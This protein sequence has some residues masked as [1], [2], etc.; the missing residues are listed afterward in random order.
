VHELHIVW[1]NII[2]GISI[3]LYLPTFTIQLYYLKSLVKVQVGHSV[4]TNVGMCND[5]WL[6]T[7]IFTYLFINYVG[8]LIP[9]HYNI[10]FE[11][12]SGGK[13][14]IHLNLRSKYFH[15]TY[16]RRFSIIR[17]IVIYYFIS[18]KYIIKFLI[19]A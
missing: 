12:I 6:R 4:H 15:V 17:T 8:I 3:N 1:T 9:Y 13:Y 10:I 16:I 19:I 5:F 7:F 14:F 18:I 11:S 2:L